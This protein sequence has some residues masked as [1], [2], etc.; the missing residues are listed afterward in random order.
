V[1]IDRRAERRPERDLAHARRAHVAPERHE[2]RLAGAE[3]R[4]IGERVRHACQR[5]DVLDERRAALVADRG[6]QRRLGAR[7]GAAAFERLERGRLLARD[8]AVVATPDLDPQLAELRLP[9]RRRERSRR[10]V[11]RGLQEQDR[12]ARAHRA[13]RQPHAPDDRLGPL[14]HHVA[15]LVGAGLALGTVR[16]HDRPSGLGPHGPPLSGGGEP[17]AA[18]PAQARLRKAL[19]EALRCGIEE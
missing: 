3:G 4:G 11:E 17:G 18:A 12:L 2:R 10:R 9:E 15:V 14:Q 7:P 13:R 16:D 8:V 6:R 19:D 1:P 5:L